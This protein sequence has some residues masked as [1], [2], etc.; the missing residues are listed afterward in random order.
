MRIASAGISN[1]EGRIS[2]RGLEA[3]GQRLP[4]DIRKVIAGE[5]ESVRGRLV[6]AIHG[7]AECARIV[8]IQAETEVQF[9]G[10]ADGMLSHG[11]YSLC[12]EIACGAEFDMN[13]FRANAFD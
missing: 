10:A 9:S 7:T 12:A 3:R 6:F 8:C 1:E 2:Q 5:I 4:E 11:L 13:T